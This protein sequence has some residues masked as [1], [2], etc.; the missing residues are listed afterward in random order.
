MYDTG[1]TTQIAVE[2]RN[3]NLT[4]LGLSETR[5]TQTGKMKLSSGE[6][7]L[8]S[9]HDSENAPHTGV[10]IMVSKTAA[11]PLIEW[12]P[13]SSRI[14]TARFYTRIQKVKLV[15]CYASTNDADQ[16]TKDSCYNSL[17]QVLNR[18]NKKDMIL[19]TGDFNAKVGEDNTGNERVM[20]KHGLGSRNENGEQFA[21]FCAV[22]SL[23]IGGTLFPHKKVLKATWISP[24]HVTEDQIDHICIGQRF[25]RSL[26]DVRVKRGADV[27]TGH[28]LLIG[29]LKFKLERFPT[30]AKRMDNR[31]HVTLL[32]DQP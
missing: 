12:E 25:G 16:E 21:E 26:L 20:G 7:L 2:M 27:A 30:D 18:Q 10:G 32:H 3:Y 9:G 13:V 5:W 6:L 1:R 8:Y 17:Q 15:Q 23:I 24:D 11:R 31:Y 14:M 29:K 4:I 19:M 28:H 22:N